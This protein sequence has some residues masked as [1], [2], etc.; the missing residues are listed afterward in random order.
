ML[1]AIAVEGGLILVALLAGW[2]LEQPA[3]SRFALDSSGLMWGLGAAVPMLGIF[4]ILVH[5]P[6]GPL[7]SIATFTDEVIRPLLK[8]C[9][10]VDLFGISCLAG[11]G[12]EMLFRGVIQDALAVKMPFVV[13]LTVA[14]CLFGLLHAVTISYAVLATLM[15]VYLGWIYE[16]S[17]N[18]LAPVLTHAVYDF[19]A[20]VYLLRWVK[21]PTRGSPGAE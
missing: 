10:I 15:G 19:V 5:W 17:G 21:Q 2:I 8:P 4:L 18:L 12:E 1:L 13:A 14:A 3:L 16:Q 20:L 9:T 11:L 7:K 6:I